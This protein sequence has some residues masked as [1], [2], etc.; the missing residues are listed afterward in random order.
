MRKA[1]VLGA[2]TAAMT[3]SLGMTAFAAQWQ[4]DDFG[5]WWQND[6]GSY[7]V[8]QWLWLDGNGDGTAECYYFDEE[9][10]CYLD[11]E[12]PDGYLVDESGAWIVDSVVQTKA[13]SEVGADTFD[14]LALTGPFDV[15]LGLDTEDDEIDDT[16]ELFRDL[17]SGDKTYDYTVEIWADG[18][19]LTCPLYNCD[20]TEQY[21]TKN[22]KELI[23]SAV[24]NGS[25]S[26]MGEFFYTK[27]NTLGFK[28]VSYEIY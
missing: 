25:L 1:I 24:N 12:T 18:A 26:M 20:G 22:R 4:E 9:G 5:W 19:A 27:D 8:S 28:L 13:A 17:V 23:Y 16:D 14:P 15:T 3:L 7:P 10:Y 2:L 11:S 21:T 6:D